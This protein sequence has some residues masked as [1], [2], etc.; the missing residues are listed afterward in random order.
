METKPKQRVYTDAEKIAAFD[1]LFP[2]FHEMHDHLEYCGWGD[3]WERSCVSSKDGGSGLIDRT[4]NAIEQ[5]PQ[6]K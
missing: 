2:L 1:V 4:A 5:Y 6:Y 3:S